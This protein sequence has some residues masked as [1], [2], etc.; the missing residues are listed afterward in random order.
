MTSKNT[1]LK[2]ALAISKLYT[3]VKVL[4]SYI[5]DNISKE[6][7]LRD[8]E[9]P[10]AEARKSELFKQRDAMEDEIEQLKLSIEVL[11]AI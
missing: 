1:P 8:I 7:E 11:E 10:Y 9:D 5:E 2:H 4:E 6:E 3:A